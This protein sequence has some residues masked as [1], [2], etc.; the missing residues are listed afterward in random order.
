[1]AKNKKMTRNAYKRKIITIGIM[2]FMSIALI[3][4]GFAA[5]VIYR[6]STTNEQSGNIKIGVVNNELMLIDITNEDDLINAEFSFEPSDGEGRVRAES[7]ERESLELE[8]FGT[9]SNYQHLW[10]EVE[11]AETSYYVH[12]K[13]DLSSIIDVATI[14]DAID[15]YNTGKDDSEKITKLDN[16]SKKVSDVVADAVTANYITNPYFTQAKFDEDNPDGTFEGQNATAVAVASL[17]DQIKI[18]CYPDA[19][20]DVVHFGFKIEF[21]WGT[22]FNGQNPSV[23]YDSPTGSAV[24]DSNVISTLNDFRAKL[25]GLTAQQ[26]QEIYLHDDFECPEVPL[27]FKVII[28]AKHNDLNGSQE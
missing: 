11:N 24:S 2:I 6:D 10:H 12:I 28:E 14:N 5:W 15:S 20:D 17:G 18:K 9:I 3:S 16:Y 22:A 23:Y 13:F 26:Y 25:F 4:T 27:G 1:M 21:K 8:V 19:T 7:T